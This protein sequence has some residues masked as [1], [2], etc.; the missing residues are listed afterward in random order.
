MRPV[1]RIKLRNR[2]RVDLNRD[3]LGDGELVDGRTLR[4]RLCRDLRIGT[5][6]ERGHSKAGSECQESAAG[7]IARY[8]ARASCQPDH[9]L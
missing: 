9:G 4:L 8:P 6:G 5:P 7:D 1:A 3:R 2:P